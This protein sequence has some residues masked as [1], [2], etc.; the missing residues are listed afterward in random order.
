MSTLL[1][2]TRGTIPAI[3]AGR[4]SSP[5]SLSGAGPTTVSTDDA[6]HSILEFTGNPSN[7]HVVNLPNKDGA[8]YIV[9]NGTTGSAVTFKVNLQT[10][11][12]VANGKRAVI[13]C[14]G[15]DYVRAA[16]DA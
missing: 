12:P 3:S 5:I 14:N 13:Y 1:S 15:S 2:G 9:H 6:E 8:I 7:P 10:G 16:P 11:V 4:K